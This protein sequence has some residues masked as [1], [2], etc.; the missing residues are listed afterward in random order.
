MYTSRFMKQ[1]L[2]LIGF[3]TM[4]STLVY[5]DRDDR[6]RL[7]KK[8]HSEQKDHSQNF[9]TPPKGYT[10]DKRF[11]HNRY[12]PRPG[13]NVQKLPPKPY[14]VRHGNDRYYYSGGIW[15]RPYSGHYVVIAPPLGLIVPV[16]PAFYTTI[17]F[18]GVPYYYAN[19]TYYVWDAGHSGYVVTTPPPNA[20]TPQPPPVEA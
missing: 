3:I 5:A 2:L 11:N 14:V 18:S 10:L 9:K 17:W 4:V 13:F 16:L 1:S 6:D 8:S 7:E 19:D 15:Y 12:Y 20:N